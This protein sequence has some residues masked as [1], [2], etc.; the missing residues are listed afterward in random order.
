MAGARAH[1][2]VAPD[3]TLSGK[4]TGLPPGEHEAQITLLS[5]RAGTRL[6]AAALLARVRQVQADMARLPV[7]DNRS[8]EDLIGYNEQ[9]HLD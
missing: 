2:R 9:G 6:G 4:A 5:S 8:P 3:G 7:L 1:I